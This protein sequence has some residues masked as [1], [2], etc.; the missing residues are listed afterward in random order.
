MEYMV[1]MYMTEFCSV[2]SG[3][4]KKEKLNIGLNKAVKATEERKT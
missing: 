4:K 2:S 3:K 1:S